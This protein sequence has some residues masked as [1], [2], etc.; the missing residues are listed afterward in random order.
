MPAG[1]GP[2]GQPRGIVGGGSRW[3]RDQAADVLFQEVPRVFYQ[4]AGILHAS[5]Y[6]LGGG[7][8]TILQDTSAASQHLGCELSDV[9]SRIAAADRTDALSQNAARI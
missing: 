9:S 5:E 7:A 3:L 8:D 6:L 1:Q 2:P 4:R